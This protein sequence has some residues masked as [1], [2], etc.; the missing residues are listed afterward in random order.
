MSSNIPSVNVSEPWFTLIK[1]GIKH[2][3]GRLLRGDFT[4]LKIGDFLTF[5][6]SELPFYR[7]FNVEIVDV[8]IY[9]SFKLY[10][11]SESLDRCLPGVDNV[12][13]GIS[14]YYKYY[15]KEDE[16]IYRVVA[17]T[18]EVVK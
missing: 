8:N 6:N 2:V 1:L 17:I 4:Q 11:Q 10:L 13:D 9:D 14:V 16:E 7:Q 18:V 15:T 5:E 3:E 12:E